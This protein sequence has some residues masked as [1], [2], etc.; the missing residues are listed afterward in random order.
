MF[1]KQR[2]VLISDTLKHQTHLFEPHVQPSSPRNGSTAIPRGAA[3]LPQLEG[4][5]RARYLRPS[6]ETPRKGA[7]PQDE[8]GVLMRQNLRQELLRPVAA[9]RAEKLLLQRVLD[10]F[11]LV[12][13]DDAV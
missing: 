10:D 1:A 5:Q 2:A 9:R 7:A 13:E 8:G 11:A 12:H 3:P 6:F 4:W